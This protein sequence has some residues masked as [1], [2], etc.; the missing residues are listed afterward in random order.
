RVVVL[1]HWPHYLAAWLERKVQV[2]YRSPRIY[3]GML[4]KSFSCNHL[5]LHATV[6]AFDDRYSITFDVLIARLCHL[7]LLWQVDPQ[8]KAVQPPACLGKFF[9]RHFTVYHAASGAHPMH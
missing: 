1:R 3:H 4:A 9:F 2:C 6:I 5:G 8:L 7:V